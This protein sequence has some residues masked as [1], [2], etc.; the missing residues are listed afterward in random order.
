MA[1]LDSV[2]PHFQGASLQVTLL[3]FRVLRCGLAKAVSFSLPFDL[4]LTDKEKG[5]RR[6]YFT[7]KYANIP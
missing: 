5:S 3:K 1:A 7:L 6:G 4:P 2:K